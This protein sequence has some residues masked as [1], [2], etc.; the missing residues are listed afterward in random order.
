[1]YEVYVYMHEG[2]PLHP[3]ACGLAFHDAYENSDI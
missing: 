2:L 1:M 3:L